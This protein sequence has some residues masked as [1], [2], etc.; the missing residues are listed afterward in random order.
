[1]QK[2]CR[3]SF[4]YGE[5]TDK[6]TIEALNL[7][8]DNHLQ[9]QF[10]I[11]LY[12]KNRKSYYRVCSTVVAPLLLWSIVCVLVSREKKCKN[13][14]TCS[15]ASALTLS[16]NIQEVKVSYQAFCSLNEMVEN[17]WFY[18]NFPQPQKAFSFIPSLSFVNTSAAKAKVNTVHLIL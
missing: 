4:M 2:S 8:L 16:F 13:C 18:R 12:K 7:A 9:D 10:E 6:N 3:V 5:L 17:R 15:P 14:A 1:M 11:L